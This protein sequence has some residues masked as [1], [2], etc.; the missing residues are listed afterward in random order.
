MERWRK[1][2]S[3]SILLSFPCPYVFSVY[4]CL[5]DGNNLLD[6]PHHHDACQ[7]VLQ[8]LTRDWLS[9]VPNRAVGSHN[10]LWCQ[11]ICVITT[12]CSLRAE[13]RQK[14]LGR[15]RKVHFIYNNYKK[16]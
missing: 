11:V 16:M 9:G 14:K 1:P 2:L 15:Y 7:H 8:L 5:R 13:D 4:V 3:Y 6:F 10:R 12:L